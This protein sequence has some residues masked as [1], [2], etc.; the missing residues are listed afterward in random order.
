[1]HFFSAP[2]AKKKGT[3]S[4]AQALSDSLSP[5]NSRKNAFGDKETADTFSVR[6]S[7]NSHSWNRQGS[8]NRG[9]ATEDRASGLSLPNQR[10]PLTTN[11]LQLEK[12]SDIL[13]QPLRRVGAAAPV[14]P[15]P[16]TSRSSGFPVCGSG[17]GLP[18]RASSAT[19]SPAASLSL[20]KEPGKVMV[21]P[22]VVDSLHSLRT[23]SQQ[24]NSSARAST[25]RVNSSPA[26]RSATISS[27]PTSLQSDVTSSMQQSPA[28]QLSPADTR[29]VWRPSGHS[30]APLPG[31]KG[32]APPAGFPVRTAV[33]SP[34]SV[35]PASTPNRQQSARSKSPVRAPAVAAPPPPPLPPTKTPLPAFTAMESVPKRCGSSFRLLKRRKSAC[36]GASGTSGGSISTITNGN[37]SA[38]ATASATKGNAAA[39]VSNSSSSPSGVK[40][41]PSR[42]EPQANSERA[43]SS[44]HG[45][46]CEPVVGFTDTVDDSPRRQKSSLS[47]VAHLVPTPPPIP[48]DKSD[49]FRGAVCTSQMRTSSM[50]S[51]HSAQS[52]EEVTYLENSVL[53]HRPHRSGVHS[54]SP[55]ATAKAASN[56]SFSLDDVP[57]PL[58]RHASTL[59]TE[60]QEALRRTPSFLSRTHTPPPLSLRELVQMRKGRRVLQCT[61]STP[62]ARATATGIPSASEQSLSSSTTVMLSGLLPS[63]DDD[64]KSVTVSSVRS[65][66]KSLLLPGRDTGG[67]ASCQ[68]SKGPAA[69]GAGAASPNDPSASGSRN[70][71]R[72]AGWRTNAAKVL[73]EAG[74]APHAPR[75]PGGETIKSP[76]LSC[77]PEPIAESAAAGE[78][79]PKMAASVPPPTRASAA[80]STSSAPPPRVSQDLHRKL[81]SSMS[82]LLDEAAAFDFYGSYMLSPP[83]FN[84]KSLYR[85]KATPTPAGALAGTGFAEE[86]VQDQRPESKQQQRPE[87]LRSSNADSAAGKAKK[88]NNVSISVSESVTV[89]VADSL[90]SAS[91][92]TAVEDADARKDEGVTSPATPNQSRRSPTH[93]HVV[94]PASRQRVVS[95]YV[96][97]DE[98]DFFQM[99]RTNSTPACASPRLQ[100]TSYGTPSRLSASASANGFDYFTSTL[101]TTKSFP[102]FLGETSPT[103]P[104]NTM[105]PTP[106]ATKSA[107]PPP[108]PVTATVSAA[109]C[110]QLDLSSDDDGDDEE[111]QYDN[112]LEGFRPAGFDARRGA[113]SNS[114]IVFYLNKEDSLSTLDIVVRA[115]SDP[116]G[117]GASSSSLNGSQLPL[118]N[119]KPPST[120]AI[121]KLTTTTTG[122]GARPHVT[123]DPYVVENT[124]PMASLTPFT[125]SSTL[126]DPQANKSFISSSGPDLYCF[127][128][129]TNSPSLQ[130]SPNARGSRTVLSRHSAS[131]SQTEA[132]IQSS[133]FSIFLG[134]TA[135]F[136]PD[137]S[138]MHRPL[139]NTFGY[140]NAQRCARAAAMAAGV[141]AEEWARTAGVDEDDVDS[142]EGIYGEVYTDENGD[143]WYW[144]EVEDEEDE[145]DEDGDEED[146]GD[147]ACTL[148]KGGARVGHC[149]A[150]TSSVSDV[151]TAA[152][153]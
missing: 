135:R 91:E 58:T 120:Y 54:T 1:M 17:S 73:S 2:H 139:A 60:Q 125:L 109:S 90:G 50:Y 41:D 57:R 64:G 94:R 138:K 77:S 37:K 93:V 56:C 128:M 63:A 149:V 126:P 30:L 152:T 98:D 65:S 29:T 15:K 148:G 45:K 95:T 106:T 89:S 114:S 136:A 107:A 137:K 23:S 84:T 22:P 66:N 14:S 111:D 118:Q 134:T 80:E 142:E 34:P 44:A 28:T 21:M 11:R 18:V 117:T 46:R 13:M 88:R 150:C 144:E 140:T 99:A 132:L 81:S 20:L 32:K 10:P 104:V 35:S 92:K 42:K 115:A 36:E 151:T 48:A 116:R 24:C 6:G 131:G 38:T 101:S 31:D 147:S 4:S 146:A 72:A 97:E 121:P 61:C 8:A 133:P 55:R 96:D 59:S 26:S 67:D 141:S 123:F 108:L 47:A 103:L 112:L 9:T 51:S 68:L 124:H 3:A 86:V 16:P 129:G 130:S 69:T 105:G 7:P 85:V 70:A 25:G 27:I 12:A 75:P 122:G 102:S 113:R 83:Q 74:A 127:A 53:V 79:D 5:K 87:T 43:G 39:G 119:Q 62:D 78:R 76:L 52:A 153:R 143:E 40:L 49:S 145:E 33:P 71:G 110:A 82:L 100:G 19:E